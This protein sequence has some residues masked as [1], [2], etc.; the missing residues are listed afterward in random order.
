MTNSDISAQTKKLAASVIR[1]APMDATNVL[2][3]EPDE[4][5]IAVLTSIE[6][7]LAQKILRNF[8]ADR[9]KIITPHLSGN[10]SDQW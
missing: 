9:S 4:V 8:P 10:I 5:V 2:L 3:E 1:R 6:P 7:L